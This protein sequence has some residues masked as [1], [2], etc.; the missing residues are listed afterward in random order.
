ME[1]NILKRIFFDKHNHWNKFLLKHENKVRRVVIK[2]IDKFKGCGK[3]VNGFKLF[4]CEGCHDVK[5]VAYR[6]KGRFCTTCSV[7]ESEEWS[8]VMSHDMFQVNHRHVIFTIDEGLREIFLLHRG[9]LKPLMDKA[10]ELLKEYFYKK[11]KVIPGIISGLHINVNTN[12]YIFA[13]VR[14]YKITRFPSLNDSSIYKNL[15][16]LKRQLRDV[17]LGL[18]LHLLT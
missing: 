10:A 15:L 2:E 12:M 16:Q 7:G 11:K 3:V 17:K 18:I 5:K 14:M 13:C 9:L 6:C 4:V 1:K 8:R